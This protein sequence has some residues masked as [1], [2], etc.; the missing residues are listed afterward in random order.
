MLRRKTCKF[1]D[2]ERIAATFFAHPGTGHG[3]VASIAK[4][5][6]FLVGGGRCTMPPE[7][8]D[9]VSLQAGAVLQLL[10]SRMTAAFLE[11]KQAVIAPA[12]A[13]SSA[14]PHTE[15]VDG[16]STVVPLPDNA[17]QFAAALEPHQA[18][19]YRTC[20]VLARNTA[21][22]EDLLQ[23]AWVKAWRHRASFDGS[24]SLYGWLLQI[25]RRTHWERVRQ[26]ARRR[27]L[28][29]AVQD[30]L[31]EV[32]DALGPAVDPEELTGT[33]QSA[34]ALLAALRQI[35][36]PFAEVV[37]LCDLEGLDYA[38]VAAHLQLPIGTVKSR[39]ARG[40]QRLRTAL[41][42]AAETD[43]SHGLASP[44]DRL[45]GGT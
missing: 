13:R 14:K 1:R 26:L 23:E 39:H 2:L 8:A 19:L 18:R 30:G 21:D 22:A 42:E 11:P 6:L 35:P 12:P 4:A 36:A 38:S 37:A 17:R 27:T 24:G 9:V 28:W 34:D 40:R 43:P 20:L 10:P 45:Q 32:W 29:E 16:V 31:S 3:L 7:A 41:T 15:A 25:V 44:S 33:V 5:G